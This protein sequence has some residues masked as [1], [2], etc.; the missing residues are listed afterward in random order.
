MV[1]V[2]RIFDS[3]VR[4]GLKSGM[5]RKWSF[6]GGAASGVFNRTTPTSVRDVEGCAVIGRIRLSFLVFRS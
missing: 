5:L 1:G 6:V 2:E 4:L 3:N